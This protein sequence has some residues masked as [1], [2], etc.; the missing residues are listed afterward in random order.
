MKPY[1]RLA[2]PFY[3]TGLAIILV[4]AV[5]YVLTVLP[6]SPTILSWRVGAVG[7]LARSVLTPLVGLVIILGTATF[8]EHVWVQRA[9]MVAGFA[10]ALA[11]IL[12]IFL[13]GL[14]LLQFR[15]QV[16]EAARRAYDASSAMI[17][18]KL[19][20]EAVVLGAFGFSG[21][22]MTRHAAAHEARHAAPAPLIARA[23]HS[24]GAPPAPPAST[25]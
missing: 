9:V 16:R 12:T 17:L 5:E 4:P 25:P 8:L 15:G 19:F 14:D 20:A 3:L 2:W 13:F 7:L 6:L 21:R 18:L 1:R 10:G 22:L 11:L 24:E 23:E